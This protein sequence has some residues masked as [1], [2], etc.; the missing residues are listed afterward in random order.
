MCGGLRGLGASLSWL[1]CC[2]GNNPQLYQRR[3]ESPI[4]QRID[5]LQKIR[6]RILQCGCRLSGCHTTFHF[7]GVA[8]FRLSGQ[9][10]LVPREGFAKEIPTFTPSSYSRLPCLSCLNMENIRV[11]CS[12]HVQQ[13]LPFGFVGI[14]PA[15]Q[16]TTC[17]AHLLLQPFPTGHFVQLSALRRR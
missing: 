12:T 14:S 4:S 3:S 6:T 15:H 2:D 11:D 5:P 9:S 1:P 16:G 17:C 7:A 8:R 13:F 10:R